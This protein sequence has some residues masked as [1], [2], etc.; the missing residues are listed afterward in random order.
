MIRDVENLLSGL[1]QCLLRCI[2]IV[3]F[4]KCDKVTIEF[5]SALKKKKS[6]PTC[7]LIW[8]TKGDRVHPM[9]REPLS[10]ANM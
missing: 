8:I 4:I 9:V 1:T 6:E 3:A 10:I 7:L 5:R 2:E